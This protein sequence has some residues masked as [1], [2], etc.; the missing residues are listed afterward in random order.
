MCIPNSLAYTPTLATPSPLCQMTPASPLRGYPSPSYWVP[1]L[2][3]AG[4]CGGLVT[5]NNAGQNP[6]KYPLFRAM[7]YTFKYGDT[8]VLQEPV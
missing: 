4:C 7:P 3:P 8:R 5:C 1:T 6:S 2:N